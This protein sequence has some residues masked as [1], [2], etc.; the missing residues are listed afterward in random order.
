MN[1]LLRGNIGLRCL[2]SKSQGGG[3]FLVCFPNKLTLT[4]FSLI[5]WILK[6]SMCDLPNKWTPW[7]KYVFD[8]WVPKVEGVKL[9]QLQKMLSYEFW[10]LKM[11]QIIGQDTVIWIFL[12]N[13]YN[14]SIKIIIICDAISREFMSSLF[15]R[16]CFFRNRSAPRD[17][18]GVEKSPG[19][20]SK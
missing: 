3:D 13:T 14:N 10:N 7:E 18:G 4:Q 16:F 2:S 6:I 1:R 9:E 15:A 20:L 5:K 12:P 19:T 11:C 17:R 8:D